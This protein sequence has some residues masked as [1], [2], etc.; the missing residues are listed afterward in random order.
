MHGRS[1]A[2]GLLPRAPSSDVQ[3][4][5]PR[6]ALI[7]SS[8]PFDTHAAGSGYRTGPE[9]D[10][11]WSDLPGLT[12]AER[13]AVDPRTGAG[14]WRLLPAPDPDGEGDD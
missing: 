2:A 10:G 9:V 5:A 11:A 14:G 8:M 13:S 3:R 1:N 4:G 7:R 6:S 12:V